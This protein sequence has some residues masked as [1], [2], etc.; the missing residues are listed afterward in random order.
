MSLY[1]IL[2]LKPNATEKEIKSAYKKLVLLYHPDKNKNP[3]AINKF[4]QI[5][6][7]YEMLMDDKIRSNYSKMNDTQKTFFQEFLEKMFNNSL[8]IDELKSFGLNLSKS[9]WDYLSKNY[10][11]LFES[12][13]IKELFNLF[14]QGTF[15][16]RDVK[17]SSNCSDSDVNVWDELNA[18]YYFELPIYYQKINKLDIRISINLSMEDLIGN[19]KKKI[20]IKRQYEDEDLFT[21]FVFT[22]DKPFIVFKDAGDMDDG[23][24]GNLII[25]LILPKH[26][27]WK[28]N[29]IYYEYQMTLYQ[30]VYGLD[31][32]LQIGKDIIEYKNWVPSRDGIL[33][34]LDKIKIKNNICAIKFVLNY[35]DTDDKH[36]I[37]KS[38]FN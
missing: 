18:E 24:W 19:N 27:I 7:A 37:L 25:Q 36:D 21:T 23:D 34:T 15:P 1:D 4:H 30:L 2:E 20:K 9:D 32:K 26:F 35:E 38:I 22:L 5:Q 10:S 6:S 13:N 17:T 31:V 29:I 8:K 14:T 11:T 33:I 16:K 28:E 3:D 12:L